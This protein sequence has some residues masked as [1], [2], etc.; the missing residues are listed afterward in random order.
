MK[1][2]SL[3]IAASA[4]AVA[5]AAGADT[6]TNEEAVPAVTAAQAKAD[7]D[8]WRAVAPERLFVFETT[9]GRIL[10]EAFPDVAP[11]HFAQ[12]TTLI[13]SGE[14]DG[15]SFHRVINGFMAQGGDIYALKGRESGLPNIPGEFTFRR[16]PAEM[17]LQ[18]AIGPVDSAKGGYV[19]G[20]PVET[21][22]SF[23]AEMS[24]DGL[25]TSWI[26]HCRGVV[27]T[28]RTSDPN[29]ANSQF[30]LMRA[31]SRHLDKEYTAWGRV[32]EGEDVVLALKPGKESEGGEVVN[33]DVLM[34]AKIAADLP[35]AERPAVW[36]MR[37]DTAEFNAELAEKGEDVTVCD[38]PSV[39]S[40]VEQ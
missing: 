26:P 7:P 25:V 14:L 19:N 6:D 33:P 12:F 36:V 17:P 29:S 20:F 5:L 18:A 40:V 1:F 3:V 4:L 27:S 16:D 13:Q 21:Q 39:A 23:F 37:T 34:S 35:V 38:L 9:K 32:V 11:K 31:T 8:H 24:L 2:A 22:A 15:T 10:I 28:A 30:F